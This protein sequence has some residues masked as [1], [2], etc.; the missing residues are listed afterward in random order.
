MQDIGIL[1]LRVCTGAFMLFGHGIGKVEKFGQLT[2]SFPDPMALGP[3]ASLILAIFAEV[4]CSTLLILGLKTR[5][6]AVPLL[7]TMLVATFIVHAAD[8]W[9][10]QEFALLYAIPFASLVLMGGGRFSLDQ[11]INKRT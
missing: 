7:V 6:V 1:I 10:K 5:F 8:P 4:V 9:A 2:S 11:L 3:K